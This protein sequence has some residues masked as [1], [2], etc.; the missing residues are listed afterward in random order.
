MVQDHVDTHPCDQ[1][2]HEFS[3]T[4]TEKTEGRV[5]LNYQGSTLSGVIVRLQMTT[6]KNPHR[7][8]QIVT[9]MLISTGM[10]LL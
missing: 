4:D 8:A 7:C 5:N 6:L 1:V 9:G 3:E 10:S 2:V